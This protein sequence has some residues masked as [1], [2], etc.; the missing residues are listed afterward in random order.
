MAHGSIR[1]IVAVAAVLS[2]CSSAPVVRYHTLMPGDVPSRSAASSSSSS[3]IAIAIVLE[4]VR[5]P[6]QVDQPQWLVRLGDGTMAILE[7]DRWASGLGDE[8]RQALR[9]QLIAGHGA[10]E[11][12][13]G[14]GSGPIRVGVDVRRFESIVSRDARTEGTWTLVGS[15]ASG[16]RVFRCEWFIRESAEAGTMSLAAAHR[17]AVARLGDAI[18]EALLKFSRNEAPSCPARDAST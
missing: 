17:R 12:R 3:S 14:A 2:G 5:V 7:R 13:P 8:F 18:A 9:E 16:A 11:A 15:E 1:L 4:P 6:A 10:I